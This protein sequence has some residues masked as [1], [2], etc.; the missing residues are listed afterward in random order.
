MKTILFCPKCKEFTMKETC[1]CGTTTVSPKPARFSEQDSVGK[2]R[3][4]ALVKERKE[5]GLL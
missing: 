4:E 1:S 2:Y 3:R 5:K